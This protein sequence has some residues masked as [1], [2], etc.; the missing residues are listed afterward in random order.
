MYT[1]MVEM[2]KLIQLTDDHG[3]RYELYWGTDYILPRNEFLLHEV[4]KIEDKLIKWYQKN[5]Y[6][7]GDSYNVEITRKGKWK[8]YHSNDYPMQHGD[9]SSHVFSESDFQ[10]AMRF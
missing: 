3:T 5:K 7:Q 9:G 10:E 1:N 8:V 6:N 2:N 4:K